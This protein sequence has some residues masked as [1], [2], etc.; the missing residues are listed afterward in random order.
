MCPEHLPALVTDQ[1]DNAVSNPCARDNAECYFNASLCQYI[2]K[3]S[4]FE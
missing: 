3:T 1:A 4:V 2:K